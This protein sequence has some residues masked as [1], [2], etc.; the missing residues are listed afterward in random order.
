MLKILGLVFGVSSLVVSGF[1]LFQSMSAMNQLAHNHSQE[2]SETK[3]EAGHASAES[4]GSSHGEGHGGGHGD[5]HGGGHGEPAREAAS[6]ASMI[7]FVSLEE[8]F[9][10][11]A[12]NEKFRTL[13][14]KID[15]E[16]FDLKDKEA[17]RSRQSVIRH[18]II[19][20]SREQAYEELSTLSGKLYFK[21]L[22]IRKM[23]DYFHKP[24]VKDVHF[25]SFFLQ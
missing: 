3:V 16:F 1:V 18:L 6:A 13:A 15:V 23:N 4:H 14:I 9:A 19:Q 11:V 10:N 8:V 17:F 12:E 24:M 25:A 7:P 21:E 5:G 20:A 22:L 2:P